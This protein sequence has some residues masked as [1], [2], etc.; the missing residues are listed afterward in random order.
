[1]EID[2]VIIVVATEIVFM[3]LTIAATYGIMRNKINKAEE[4]IAE[5]KKAL[6]DKADKEDHDRVERHLQ[7]HVK[8]GQKVLSA[9]ERVE[10]KIDLHMAN[11][12]DH[13]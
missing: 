12:T 7:E 4:D 8:D 1:M 2:P 13:K 10:T 5:L 3:G 6:K 11:G 9:M